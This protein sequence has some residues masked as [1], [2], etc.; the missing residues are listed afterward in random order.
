MALSRLR[1]RI[2]IFHYCEKINSI[3]SPVFCIHKCYSLSFLSHLPVIFSLFA[4]CIDPARDRN[5]VI[6]SLYLSLASQRYVTRF[7]C[8]LLLVSL[9]CLP[10]L[11]FLFRSNRPCFSSSDAFAGHFELS[12]KFL[13]IR[14]HE[15]FIKFLGKN[16]KTTK[17]C[18]K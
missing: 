17:L 6:N 13:R 16:R 12:A 4:R 2:S 8:P 10:V 1:L 9:F 5:R 18:L 11:R 7:S 3:D 14:L 15:C